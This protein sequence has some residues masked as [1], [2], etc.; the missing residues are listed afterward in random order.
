[1]SSNDDIEDEISRI[2]TML[3]SYKSHSQ[4]IRSHLDTGMR[5]STPRDSGVGTARSSLGATYDDGT[6]NKTFPS[7]SVFDDNAD[8]TRNK[9]FHTPVSS[10]STVVS[11]VVTSTPLV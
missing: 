4:T 9:T 6:R 11:S 2:E 7:S 8:G 1:M 3:D 10:D 5:F